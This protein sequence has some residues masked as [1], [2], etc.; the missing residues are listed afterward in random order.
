[1]IINVPQG[2]NILYS[3]S[4]TDYVMN[5]VDVNV[6]DFSATDAS[7]L[8]AY[9]KTT[10]TGKKQLYTYNLDTSARSF[11]FSGDI[12][13]ISLSPSGTYIAYATEMTSQ[14][15]TQSVWLVNS[16]ND[17]PVQLTANTAVNGGGLFWEADEKKILFSTSK[18]VATDTNPVYAVYRLTFIL[19]YLKEQK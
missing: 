4:D 17:V 13:K 8:V 6:S 18:S 7:S 14:S 2:S 5:A 15:T 10:T 9:I 19:E 1:M 11:L 16:K 12:E 3:V